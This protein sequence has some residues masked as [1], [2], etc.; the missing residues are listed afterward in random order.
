MHT[1]THKHFTYLAAGPL[2]GHGNRVARVET[3]GVA[4]PAQLELEATRPKRR[5]AVKR[6]M[7]RRMRK[8]EKGR[9][10]EIE[11]WGEG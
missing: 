9:K 2:P 11:K 4:K 8:R 5:E 7:K 6:P 10:R 1:L 3:R